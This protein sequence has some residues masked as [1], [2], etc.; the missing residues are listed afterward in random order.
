MCEILGIL[1]GYDMT[2]LGFHSAQSV[3]LMAEAM[4]YAYADRN[5]YLGDPAFTRNPIDRLLSTDY[6]RPPSATRSARARRPRRRSPAGC[7][8]TKN[9]RPRS[10]PCSTAPATPCR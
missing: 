1:G 2:S 9:P 6:A 5:T 7:R 8:P 3:H 10:I 4:R